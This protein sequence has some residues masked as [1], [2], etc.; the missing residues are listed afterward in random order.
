[1][2]KPKDS[3][4][5]W[6]SYIDSTGRRVRRSTGTADKKEAAALEAKWKLETHQ[7]KKWDKEPSRTFGELMLAYME[8]PSKDKRSH[9]RDWFSLTRLN[10][11]FNGR[12]LSSITATD[13][14]QYIAKRTAAGVG[15]STINKEIA[16]FRVALNW[17]RK[18]LEW[19]I[20]NPFAGRKLKEPQGRIRWITREES[21][22]LIASAKSEPN[23]QHVVDFIR[24]GLNTGMRSGEM[25]G[26]E[27]ERVDLA[28]NLVY[29]DA[30]HQ[31]S[32]KIG[33]VPLNR[34]AREAIL[35]RARFR[36]EN[37]P[38]SPWVFAHETGDRIKSVHKGFLGSCKRIGLKDFHPHD[39]RHTCA[40]WLVQAGVSIREVAELLRHSDIRVTMRYAHLSPDNVRAA[41][42]LLDAPESSRSGFSRGGNVTS[43]LKAV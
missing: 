10:E 8:G 38:A 15:P 26:L 9:K 24:L 22:R 29:L 35:S 36:A 1:M 4:F 19:N 23:S 17:A 3:Q 16:L 33:S 27:W 40:A 5:W 41:V 28:A 31:K 11:V 6:A 13:V 7:Q 12:E 37:C 32:G 20:S 39:L 43:I 14:R 18:E 42:S 21:Q 34:E 2:Y 30:K 25:L